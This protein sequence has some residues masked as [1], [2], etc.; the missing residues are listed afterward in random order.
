M[1]KCESVERPQELEG[2]SFV[3]TGGPE[4]HKFIRSVLCTSSKSSRYP[5]NLFKQ[6]QKGFRTISFRVSVSSPTA[7]A[8]SATTARNSS[9]FEPPLSSLCRRNMTRYCTRSGR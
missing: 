6:K 2:H 1:N 8:Y 5:I 9:I 3:E 7:D 4:I